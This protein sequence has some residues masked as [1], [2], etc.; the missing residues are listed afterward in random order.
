M[1]TP[2]ETANADTTR[3]DQ[4][5][6]EVDDAQSELQR[7]HSDKNADD[8][9]PDSTLSASDKN[10]DCEK[11]LEKI[12]LLVKQLKQSLEDGQL[13]EC[14]SLYEKCQARLKNL[15]ELNYKPNSR[16][17]IQRKLNKSRFEIQKLKQWR[18]WGMNQARLELIEQ[19]NALKDSEEHPKDIYT[20]LKQ[21]REQ[22]ESWNKS[23]DFP[24][25]KLRESF[26]EAYSLAFT[27]CRIYFKDQKKLRKQNQK[28][29]KR[30]CA[31]LEELFESIDWNRQPDWK[32][33][34]D[35]VRM[36]KKRWKEAVPLNKKDWVSTNARFDKVMDLFRP[37]L[38]RERE[39]GIEYR[40]DLINKANALDS[41]PVNIAIEKAKSYQSDWKSVVIR[42]KKKKENELW[43]AF[44]SA[45]DKQFQRRAELRKTRDKVR[46][47]NTQQ[48]KDLLQELKAINKTETREIEGFAAQVSN[49]QHRWKGI[50]D[51]QRNRKN[52][53]TT[54]FNN[55]ISKFRRAVR[56]AKRL[57][58]E[59]TFIALEQKAQIC[60]ALEFAVQSGDA[61]TTLEAH[62]SQWNRTD[63]SCG[64]FEAAIQQ[65]F[66]AACALSR[67]S[68]GES[69]LNLDEQAM[70]NLKLK[71]DICLRLEVLS[72]IESPPEFTRQRMQYNVERLNAAMTKQSSQQDLETEFSD[73]LVQYWLTGAVPNDQHPVLKERFEKIR[74]VSRK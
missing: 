49:I 62:E 34:E 20:K 21:I 51:F 43:H 40:L 4:I 38:E 60:D 55:E 50:D 48:K 58:I 13:K 8:I 64:E 36:A 54:E 27:P 52:P 25:S 29:R 26:S 66:D 41:E 67:D 16:K 74:A 70:K 10:I 73:L 56:D 47:E 17:K 35:A 24:S 6:A 5:S 33:I 44:K 7:E 19:L 11:D 57:K 46:Q 28:L 14:I 63:H 68:T 59:A 45:C 3:V 72:E 69:T 37:H 1:N 23:G 22:W 2:T 39:K 9:R 71:Q 31:E 61:M 30:V 42:T 12:K 18:H 65:R 53:I 15:E 32:A